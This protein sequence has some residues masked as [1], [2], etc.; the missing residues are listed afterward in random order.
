M[1]LSVIIHS[2]TNYHRYT[3]SSVEYVLWYVAI[4]QAARAGKTLWLVPV[5]ISYE[6][7][8]EQADLS[9]ELSNAN[10]EGEGGGTSTSSSSASLPALLR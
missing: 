4:H 10:V 2:V 9:A 6:R 8:P 1:M 5:S 7:V 3:L